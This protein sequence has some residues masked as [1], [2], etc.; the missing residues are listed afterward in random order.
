MLRNFYL[1]SRLM[2]SIMQR[3]QV[4]VAIESWPKIETCNVM[5]W[6][7]WVKNQT[8]S[9]SELIFTA[10]LIYKQLTFKYDN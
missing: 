8:M 7:F 6:C 4:T 9:L 5:F 10:L 2:M 1:Q 3:F